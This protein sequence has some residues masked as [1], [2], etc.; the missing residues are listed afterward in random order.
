MRQSLVVLIF[1][2]IFS[3]VLQAQNQETYLT[4]K[5]ISGCQ[6][7]IEPIAKQLG[8]INLSYS[9]METGIDTIKVVFGRSTKGERNGYWISSYINNKYETFSTVEVIKNES[10]QSLTSILNISFNNSSKKISLQLTINN[11]TNEIQYLWFDKNNQKSKIASI[12]NIEKP[13]QKNKLFPPMKVVSLNG[14]SIS[15]KDFIVKFIVINWWATGCAP[16]RQEI[17]G[18]NSLVE[19]YKSNSG[20]VFL[21]VAFDKKKDLEYYLNLKEFKYK[22]TMGGKETVK[23]FGESFP[24]NI[25]VNPQ[26]M[27]TFYSEGGNKYKYLDIDKELKSQMENK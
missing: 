10:S 19:K 3:G 5:F 12:I 9:N 25:I 1:G 8:L 22:Q 17:P 15:V 2:L 18:L 7:E 13:L 26:G 6:I 27:I 4:S 20:V 16:C 24:K 23:L 21:A 14:D 11:L